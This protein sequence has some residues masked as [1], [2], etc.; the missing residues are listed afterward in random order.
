VVN[1]RLQT[2]QA[3]LL[4]MMLLAGG[5]VLPK[6][7]SGCPLSGQQ[8]V[9]QDEAFHPCC[10]AEVAESPAQ[11]SSELP[12]QPEDGCDCPFGCCAPTWAK[13][14]PSAAGTSPELITP[15]GWEL[16]VDHA[17]AGPVADGPRRPPRV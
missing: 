4:A 5:P 1:L 7:C 11:P 13:A 2:L 6:V 17:L 12:A 9:L 14:V 16:T 8:A 15:A 3:W 10:G